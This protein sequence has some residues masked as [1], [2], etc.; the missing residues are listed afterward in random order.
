MDNTVNLLVHKLFDTIS[1]RSS[2]GHVVKL[3]CAN[4]SKCFFCRIL[5]GGW[6]TSLTRYI[7]KQWGFKFLISA[8][9]GEVNE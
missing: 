2:V 4:C 7:R 3:N 8:F 9:I 5:M 1:L 6:L